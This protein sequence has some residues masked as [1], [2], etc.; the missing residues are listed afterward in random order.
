L[1]ISPAEQI[2]I[3]LS[4]FEQCKKTANLMMQSKAYKAEEILTGTQILE[5]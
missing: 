2:L 4:N 5:N 1:I 3:V